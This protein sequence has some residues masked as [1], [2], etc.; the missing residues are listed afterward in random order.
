MDASLE[1][2]A[3]DEVSMA[4]NIINERID[5]QNANGIAHWNKEEYLTKHFPE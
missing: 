3:A 5:W 1:C 4:I 2:A